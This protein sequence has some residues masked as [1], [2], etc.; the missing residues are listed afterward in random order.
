MNAQRKTSPSSD[1]FRPA[2]LIF[3]INR[4]SATN[5]FDFEIRSNEKTFNTTHSIQST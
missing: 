2:G 4:N 5:R 1:I 3:G